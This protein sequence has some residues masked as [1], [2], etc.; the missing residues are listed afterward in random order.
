[1]PHLAWRVRR[2]TNWHT[3]RAKR[4]NRQGKVFIFP[5]LKRW[6]ICTL[7]TT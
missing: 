3:K 6:K 5:M 4:S 7:S 2:L 1:M